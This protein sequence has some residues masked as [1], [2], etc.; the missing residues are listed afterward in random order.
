M[1]ILNQNSS[2]DYFK[3]R[4]QSVEELITYH[5]YGVT[6]PQNGLNV[7]NVNANNL[8]LV[9]R[10]F[11]KLIPTTGKKKTPQRACIRF[12]CQ[13]KKLP[14][15]NSRKRSH[16]RHDTQYYCPDYNVALCLNNCFKAHH[17]LVDYTTALPYEVPDT[18]STSS[19]DE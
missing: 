7:Q 18:E 3:F 16:N 14:K 6:N 10:H 17:T 9:K 8:R 2:T 19:D 15:N 4:I 13:Q 11:P 12:N 1:E 5:K